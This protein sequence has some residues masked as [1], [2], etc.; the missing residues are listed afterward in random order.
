MEVE[1]LAQQVERHDHALG[2]P[3][4]PP[5]APRRGPAR[6][7]GL[8][9]LPQGEVGRVALLLGAEDLPLAAADQHLVERLVG[10]EAVVLDGADVHVDAVVGR[11]G[12]ADLDQ[13][14]D[15]GDHLVDVVGGVGDVGRRVDPDALASP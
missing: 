5:V 12:A 1:P 3:A 14:A 15:H 7:A 2:V 11:V 9:Q 6:L 4:R 10:E 13:L 8:G